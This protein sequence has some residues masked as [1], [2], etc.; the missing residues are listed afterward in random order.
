MPLQYVHA[1]SIAG[2]LRTYLEPLLPVPLQAIYPVLIAGHT[3][4]SIHL[5]CT[6]KG[7]GT[8]QCIAIGATPNPHLQNPLLGISSEN[9]HSAG[10]TTGV[11][12][13]FAYAFT[14]EPE[15][16]QG[17]RNTN[18]DTAG[19]GLMTGCQVSAA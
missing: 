9:M 12:W 5:T 18:L 8:F 19:A 13:P 10:A 14:A 7:L 6:W 3:V 11:L 2:T 15:K 17:T 1:N 4:L 16:V